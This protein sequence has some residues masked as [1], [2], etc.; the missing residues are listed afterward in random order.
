ML[1]ETT[2]RRFING[3]NQKKQRKKIITLNFNHVTLRKFFIYG[4]LQVIIKQGK[5]FLSSRPNKCHNFNKMFKFPQ[6]GGVKV[7][8]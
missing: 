6:F 1:I 2:N 4:Q 7:I 8:P 5:P 3:K